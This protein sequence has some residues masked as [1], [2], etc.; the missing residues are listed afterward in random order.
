MSMFSYCSSLTQAPALPATT[1]ESKCYAFMF[2]ACTSLTKAPALPAMTLASNCYISMFTNCSS[3]TQ[4]PALPATTFANICYSTMFSGCTSLKLSTTKTDEYKIAYRIP[5]SGEGPTGSNALTSMFT[6]TGGTFTGDPEVNTTYYLSSDNIVVHE[7]EVA[8]LNGYVG[9]M[10]DAKSNASSIIEQNKGLAQKFWR[11]TT[12][13]YEA[14][15]TKSDDT[16]YIITDT[17][18]IA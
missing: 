15:S 3:L 7:T 9:S 18:E 5:S 12:A 8:T 11:G 1:L 17:E 10:I 16:M 4:I 13:E 6:E 2:S 14:L